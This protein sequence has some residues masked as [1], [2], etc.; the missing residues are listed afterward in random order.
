MKQRFR[1]LQ[2]TSLVSVV[3]FAGVFLPGEAVLASVTTYDLAADWSDAANPNGAWTYREGTDALPSVSDWRWLT[4][5]V[6]QPAWAPSPDHRNFLPAWFKSRSNNPEGQDFLTGDVVVH[7]TDLSNGANHGPANIMW[8]SPVDGAITVSGGVW[9]TRASGRSNVWELFLN[10]TLLT[11]GSIYDGDPFSRA[12]PFAFASGSGGPGALTELTVSKNDVIELRITKTSTSGDFVG[13]VLTIELE[14]NADSDGDGVL[15]DVDVC[16]GGDDNLDTDTDGVADFCD[17]CPNDLT[18]DADGDGI[19]ADVDVCPGGDD[20]LNADGDDLPDFCDVCPIDPENDA[21]ADGICESDDNCPIIANENQSDL[22][23]DLLGDAC[24]D[25]IDG[26]G[27]GG[28]TPDNCPFDVNT[29]QSDIDGDGA[30]DVCDADLDGDG[31]LDA[32][33]PCVPSPVGDAV[34]ADGC[35]ISDLAPCEH[36]VGEDR[37]KNHGAY[38]SAVAHVANDFRADGLITEAERDSVVSDAGNSTCGDKN[39]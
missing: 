36:A 22:D 28:G 11:S 38:V 16:P 27:L 19:C 15:D 32:D 35:S 26:D 39:K 6:T 10:G 25:D 34:N 2:R 12:N 9:M 17:A 13:V 5:P 37:W 14:D 24:D 23:G 4:S 18:N 8:T 21:D 30:G 20:N 3:V 33:D 31:V 1:C 29:D 7:T